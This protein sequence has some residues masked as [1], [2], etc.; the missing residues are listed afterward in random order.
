MVREPGDPVTVDASSLVERVGRRLRAR[1][2]ALRRTLADVAAEAGVSVS[3]LS[4]VEKGANQPSLLVLARIVHAL[5]LTIADVVRAEGQNRL[6]TSH[7]D[8]ELAETSLSH[9]G[10]QLAIVDVV[11]EPGDEG[12]CPVTHGRHDVFVFVRRGALAV[13]VDGDEHELLAGD[14]LGARAPGSVSWRAGGA[15]QV[16]AIW[17]ST[18]T[19]AER[20][21]D[22][23]P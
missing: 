14:S 11:S 6:I 4:A 9:S 1:R 10:L 3:Y 21:T 12:P 13:T 8:E 20:A 18:P 19:H 22:E 17:V 15:A 23:R 7:L 2:K 5:D 16:A